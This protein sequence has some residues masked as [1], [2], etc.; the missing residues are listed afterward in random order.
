M[1]PPLSY[2]AFSL[3]L[4]H[5]TGFYAYFFV[6]LNELGWGQFLINN[7]GLAVFFAALGA[8]LVTA[9]NQVE[10]WIASPVRPTGSP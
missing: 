6:D 8:V 7:A 10:P 3:V 9:K 2:G 5:L 1:V 4:G